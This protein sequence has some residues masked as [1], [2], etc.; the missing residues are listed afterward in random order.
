MSCCL[1]VCLFYVLVTT[2]GVKVAFDDTDILA[3][4][5]VRIVARMSA[6]PRAEN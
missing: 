1:S 4:I 5:L 6:C 3:D 2:S